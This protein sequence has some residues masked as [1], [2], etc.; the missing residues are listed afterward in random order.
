MTEG[1]VGGGAQGAAPLDSRAV[2]SPPS[3]SAPAL[4]SSAVDRPRASLL[5]RRF[6]VVGA[7]R[8]VPL[9]AWVCALIALLNAVSWSLI[10]PPFQGKDEA[11][12]FAY[13]E[14]LVENHVLPENGQQNGVYS[15]EEQIVLNAVRYPQVTHSPQNLAITSL[16]QQHT[17]TEALHANNS[18][19]GSGEAGIATSEPPLYYALQIIPYEIGRGNILV[20][21]QLM[22]LVGAL[23][24]A[25]TAL[26]T[27]LFV[28]EVMPR[29]RWAAT[30]G[31]LCVALQ[32][33][34]AFMSGSVNPDSMLFGEAAA[35]FF[36]LARALRRGL[37]PRLA[38]ALGAI[39]AAGFLTK[40]NFVG[41]AFGVFVGIV[42]LAWRGIRASGWRGGIPAMIAAGIGVSPVLLYAFR[43]IAL[44]HP[45]FGIVTGSSD[46]LSGKS[47]LDELSYLWEI[48]LPRLPGMTHY[49]EGILTSKDIWFDRSVGLYGWMDTM[50]PV[51]VDNV[52]LVPAAVVAALCGRELFA[53]RHV[54][55]ARWAELSIYTIIT[56]GVLVMIGISSYISDALGGGPAFGEPRYLLPMLPLFGAALALAVRGAGRRW[57]PVVGAALVVLI[58]GYD[59]VSQ[60][61]VVARY[62]G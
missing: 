52:A 18:L 1:P 27:F 41:F 40:L 53:R 49:F 39:I 32:P 6:V 26:F 42:V 12:H 16:A 19:T 5:G 43:N 55:R 56:L 30:I 45:L 14:D 10:V 21:L 20:Q 2:T 17:L 58:F 13:V 59:I 44:G 15:A 51:W 24:G 61:Q 22:R 3:S 34:L 35:I 9:A 48:Y 38:V 37:T 36:C 46:L 4:R 7:L 60:L 47:L 28:R 11:D 25:L 33:L 8:G 31:A 62:Y 23:F 29:E 57:A 50:F 54:L